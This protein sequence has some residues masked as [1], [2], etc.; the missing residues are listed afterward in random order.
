MVLSRALN[1]IYM[2]SQECLA[3][4]NKK[5]KYCVMKLTSACF[6]LLTYCQIKVNI[7]SSSH[8]RLPVPER[9][10]RNFFLF[11]SFHINRELSYHLL[12][13]KHMSW[14]HLFVIAILLIELDSS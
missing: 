12:F 6:F 9:L 11:F 7:F 13:C 1:L 5:L 8:K 2:P 4:Q 14:G 3:K 10:S